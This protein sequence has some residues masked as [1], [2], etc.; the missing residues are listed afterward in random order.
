VGALAIHVACLSPGGVCHLTHI[1]LDPRLVRVGPVNVNT[2]PVQVLRALPG[3]T[4]AVAERI[5]A[6]RPYG[7]WQDKGRGIGD[8]L[9][10]DVLGSTEE[11]RLALF[12]RLAHLV[13][14]RSDV[15]EIIA[16][17]QAMVADRLVAAQ[18]IVTVVQRQ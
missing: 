14:T 5:V 18:R 4:A 6:G 3:V 2:A 7:D 13:T 12:R 17:G 9:V 1:W 15:F 11:D 10:G 8:L 16:L